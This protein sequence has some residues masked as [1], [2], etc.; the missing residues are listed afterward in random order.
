M[1]PGANL[2]MSNKF[3][4]RDAM[5]ESVFVGRVG[6]ERESFYTRGKPSTCV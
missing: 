2:S 4:V 3:F 5:D 6:G 1:R